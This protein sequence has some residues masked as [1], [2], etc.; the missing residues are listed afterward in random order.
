VE[1]I[2]PVQL[3]IRLLLPEGSLLLQLPEI[4][5]MIE[6]FDARGLC[7]RWQNGDGKLDALCASIQET[8]KREERHRRSRWEIFRKIWELAQ[9]GEF[10][11]DAPMVSRATIPYLTEPWYC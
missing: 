7:Y 5:A 6:P 9:A 2:A 10:P 4:R 3:A 8:I 11:V 1:Q